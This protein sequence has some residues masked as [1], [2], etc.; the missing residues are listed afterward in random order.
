MDKI[1]DVTSKTEFDSIVKNS[2]LPVLVDCWATWCAPCRMQAPILNSLVEEF[3]ENVNV[4]KVNV[5]ENEDIANELQI[6]SIPT[7]ILYVNGEIKEK[8]IGLTNK[9]ELINLIKKY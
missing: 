5:D 4:I 7:L 6:R 1:I 3:G 9:N 8:L 2:N